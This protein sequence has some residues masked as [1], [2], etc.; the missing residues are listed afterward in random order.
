[1]WISLS[2]KYD[3][4]FIA[5]IKIINNKQSEFSKKQKSAIFGKKSNGLENPNLKTVIIEAVS[6]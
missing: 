1:M 6:K 5:Q 3:Q 4:A 2:F